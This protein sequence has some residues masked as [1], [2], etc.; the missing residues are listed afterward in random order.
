M[1]EN[2]VDRRTVAKGI[3]WAAPVLLVGNQAP[4]FAAS[5]PVGFAHRTTWRWYSNNA[6]WCASGLDGLEIN[7]TETGGGVSFT[8][9]TPATKI[10]NVSATFY[11]TRSDLI[12]SPTS[13]SSTSWT[14]PTLQSGSVK[15]TGS[16]GVTRT[17]YPYLTTFTGAIA[18]VNGT[19]TLPTYQFQTQCLNVDDTTWAAARWARRV[20][21]ATIDGSVSTTD[22]GAFQVKNA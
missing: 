14:T 5:T 11:F 6:P 4:V 10:T 16:D 12:W 1:V 21:T 2:A 13:S 7:T 17:Y 3:A 22:T 8:G 15:L 20:A 9:T 19:T 18:A